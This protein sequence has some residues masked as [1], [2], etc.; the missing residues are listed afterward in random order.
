MNL[1][2]SFSLFLNILNHVFFTLFVIFPFVSGFILALS[3]FEN[4]ALPYRFVLFTIIIILSSS[5]QL[6][7]LPELLSKL[8]MLKLIIGNLIVLTSGYLFSKKLSKYNLLN[9]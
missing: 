8:L 6:I 7:F 5:L 4:K 9:S 3:K 2:E 1:D